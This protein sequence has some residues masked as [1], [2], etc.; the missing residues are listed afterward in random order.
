MLQDGQAWA[1]F[2]GFDNH[3][4]KTVTLNSALQLSTVW[5]CIRLT[6]QAV[7]CLP[8]GV[9]DKAEHDS[10]EKVDDDLSDLLCESP[11]EDQTPLEFWET[12]VAWLLAD[13]N[14]YAEKNSIG[15]RLVALQPM[16]SSQCSPYRK[17]DGTLVYRFV[18]RGKMEE[19]PREK[20]FHLRGMSFGGDRGLSPIRFGAQ[21]FG[22]AMAMSETTG[23]MYGCGLQSTGF[24]KMPPGVK[25]DKEQ[26]DQLQ[27]IMS[28]FAGSSNAGKLMVLEGGMDFTPLALA[29]VDAQMLES[30][31]FSVEELCRW[32]GMPPIIIGHAAQGQTMWGTGVEA[33]LTA[34]S[35]LGIDPVC[36][37]IEARVKKDLIRPT[38]NRRRYFEFNREALLQMDSDA[39]AKFLSAMT[40]NGLMTRN[41][42]R[43]KLNLPWKEGGDALTA[44]TNLAPLDQLGGA[45]SEGAQARAAIRSWLGIKEQDLSHEQ[46]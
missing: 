1:S 37:R 24:L 34:W 14:A 32:F 33:I 10:R 8:A 42:G 13:G 22:S 36:D 44:Q 15:K 28:K 7:S 3:A 11:N 29:P 35:T 20:V 12:Q 16:A 18:D 19:L 41:E 17:A 45:G 30:L 4:G 5:A 31:R 40:Q 21:S 2:A 27:D 39:K 9:Y 25:L 6:A 43:G 46:A 26:R 38:G 23:K